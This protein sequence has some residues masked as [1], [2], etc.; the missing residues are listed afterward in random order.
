MLAAEKRI[1]AVL[2]VVL[3][4]TVALYWPG[5]SGAFLLD[6]FQNLKLLDILNTPGV[7]HPYIQYFAEVSSGAGGRPI[8][9]L[10]FALQHG[11]WPSHPENFRLVNLFLHLINGVLLYV[12][13]A[14]LGAMNGIADLTAR[15]CALIA[16]TVWLVHPLNVSTVLYI[17]QRMTELATLFTLAGLVCYV[18]GRQ[19][20]AH[21]AYRSGYLWMSLGIGLFGVLAALSKENGVLLIVYA[22]AIEFTLL[23]TLP[24]PHHWQWWA[25][26]FLYI[27]LL[28]L[29]AYLGQFA[30][31]AIRYGFPYRDFTPTERLLTESRVLLDYLG[32]IYLP[33]PEKFGLF[34]D[35]FPIS[36]HLFE[37]T[38]IFAIT[39]IAMLLI[40][41]T[42]FVKRAPTYGFA[43]FWF[44]GGHAL[45]STII[46]LELYFEHRNYLPMI[47]PL[48]L[49]VVVIARLTRKAQSRLTHLLPYA[50]AATLILLVIMTYQETALWGDPYRQAV[51]WAQEKPLSRRAQHQAASIMIVHGEHDRAADIYAK[52]VRLRPLEG[53]NYVS[54]LGLGCR[55]ET[56]KLPEFEIV[57][58]QLRH[59]KNYNSAILALNRIVTLH[60][61]GRCEH[62]ERRQIF[63][64]VHAMIENPNFHNHLGI[65][66]A[67]EGRL[68]AAAGWLDGAMHSLDKSFVYST[69]FD[70][71]DITLLQVKFLASAGLYDDAMDYI[72]KARIEMRKGA[73]SHFLYEDAVE[74]LAREI[75]RVRAPHAT[76]QE[77]RSVLTVV[78][79]HKDHVNLY[80]KSNYRDAP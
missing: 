51:T 63:R 4:S 75:E 17:V 7:L 35:D 23:R 13:L 11:S 18:E 15:W 44:F 24:R 50:G 71:V 78:D 52:L 69:P 79:A 32:K 16:T 20:I 25:A 53:D 43:V 33:R 6:D 45:E 60:E 1:A 28:L 29:A 14:R 42:I 70:R 57:I 10:S 21:K 65:L 26:A 46:G 66:Y 58:D 59:S 55:D 47:G 77:S 68:H 40:S 27:P 67:F 34:H 54:W 36:T 49:G 8:S 2:L 9:F 48:F 41:A 22:L 76:G 19:R 38:T 31:D 72:N 30:A 37:P 80:E 39:V 64:L 61:D 74:H 73:F 56:V 62:I 12:L 5:L 3:G